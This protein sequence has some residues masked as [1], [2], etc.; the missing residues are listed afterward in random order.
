MSWSVGS[1]AAILSWKLMHLL[2]CF[3]M[4]LLLKY[5]RPAMFVRFSWC[6]L[7]CVCYCDATGHAAM[8]SQFRLACF[9]ANSF[10]CMFRFPCQYSFVLQFQCILMLLACGNKSWIDWLIDVLNHHQVT[11][12]SGIGAGRWAL[13]P[14]HG[15]KSRLGRPHF[16]H[17]CVAVHLK[18]ASSYNTKS[19]SLI[20]F[21]KFSFLL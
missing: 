16:T 7:I 3:S 6:F 11:W 10:S 15:F 18:S 1:Q 2:F 9:N 5:V 17:D 14:H 19:C 4:L 20:C 21:F 8:S 12:L 13:K